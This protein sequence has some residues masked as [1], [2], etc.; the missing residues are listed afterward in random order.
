[1]KK[2]AFIC[3]IISSILFSC[4]SNDSRQDKEA[5]VQQIINSNKTV[6]IN[7]LIMSKVKSHQVVLLGENRHNQYIYH[8]KV[9]ELLN[10]WLK[11]LENN[12]DLPREI[13][14]ILEQP[15]YFGQK[16]NSF[17]SNGDI[18]QLAYD[19]HF[20]LNAT[21]A[22]LEFFQDLKNLNEQ[23]KNL[24]KDKFKENPVA[25]KVICVEKDIPMMAGKE[26]RDN[27]FQT[28]RDIYTANKIEENIT[29]LLSYRFIGTFGAFHI[30]KR[31]DSSN[32]I[33]RLAHELQNGGVK[34]Y[35][36][37]CR[38]FSENPF[39]FNYNSAQKDFAL[40]LSAINKFNFA[41][42]IDD[43]DAYIFYNTN[44]F[45]D[46]VVNNIPSRNLI[47]NY[48]DYAKQYPRYY[49]SLLFWL[50]YRFT[51]EMVGRGENLIDYIENRLDGI[52]TTDL[53]DKMT[54]FEN[55]F[56]MFEKLN[57]PGPEIKRVLVNLTGYSEYKETH[58]IPD[59]SSAI[60]YWKDYVDNNKEKIKVRLFTS[61][62]YYGTESE[63]S[64]ALE[65]L[66]QLSGKNFT[67][68]KEWL[69]WYREK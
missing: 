27:F 66:K 26:V 15:Q 56:N 2:F 11:Q 65:K 42:K 45:N 67:T 59:D 1:M 7:E 22:D 5:I 41:A 33:P 55:M 24:N 53:I 48:L 23:V 3:F 8:Q 39:G 25:F 34:I 12:E 20:V 60:E 40:P 13:C 28:E 9:I 35:T 47:K 49:S 10:Y 29:S 46:I 64:K 44:Y 61:V 31:R 43:V 16:L 19:S 37:D 62:L 30:A 51:G 58:F 6:K 63:Q 69:N 54:L 36:F 32:N 18:S 50:W 21:V 14:L 17:L 57:V 38:L 68:K 52:N 4:S